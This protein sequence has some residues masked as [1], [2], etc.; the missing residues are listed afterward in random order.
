MVALQRSRETPVDV[1]QPENSVSD[2][3]EI[4]KGRRDPT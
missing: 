2:G 3:L 1:A 4:A